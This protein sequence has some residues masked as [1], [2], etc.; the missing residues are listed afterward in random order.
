MSRRV[1]PRTVLLVVGV[2][3]T[4]A[5]VANQPTSTHATFAFAV[6]LCLIFGSVGTTLV[7]V[8]AYFAAQAMARGAWMLGGPASVALVMLSYMAQKLLV[9]VLLG[10]FVSRATTFEGIGAALARMHAPR[11]ITLPLMVMLRFAPTIHSDAHALIDSLRTRGI[12]DSASWLLVHPGALVELVV[13]PLL[14]HATRVADD[15]SASG[16]TRGLGQVRGP[17][18]IYPLGF[19]TADAALAILTL[20]WGTMLVWLQTSTG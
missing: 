9:F 10:A 5:I 13:V 16:L 4:L 14:M 1:D 8:V 20:S 15:L 17:A 18:S 3:G 2:I 12:I 19:S 7:A 11:A 6:L